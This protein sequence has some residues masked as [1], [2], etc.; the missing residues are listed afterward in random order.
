MRH[1]ELYLEIDR[2]VKSLNSRNTSLRI[3]VDNIQ[4]ERRLFK[5]RE[6]V[7]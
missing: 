7:A 2:M 5:S 4:I 1:H 6:K 3:S